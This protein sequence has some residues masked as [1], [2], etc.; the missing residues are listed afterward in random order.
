MTGALPAPSALPTARFIRVRLVCRTCRHRMDGDL[1]RLAI[2]R[3]FADAPFTNLPWR[4]SRCG[5]RRVTAL[6]MDP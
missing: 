3:R 6:V 2:N 4:C 5:S 1:R